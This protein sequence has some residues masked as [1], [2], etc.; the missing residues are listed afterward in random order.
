MFLDGKATGIF[1]LPNK[2]CRARKQKC[3]VAL[4]HNALISINNFPDAGFM[5]VTDL[6]WIK[7]EEARSA[8]TLVVL[9][10]VSSP[11]H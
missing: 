5:R 11:M 7:R 3:I 9:A 4:T 6:K 1:S 8:E 2:K 10:F